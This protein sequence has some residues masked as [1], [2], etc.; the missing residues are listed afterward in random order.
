MQSVLET[1]PKWL[2]ETEVL[3]L[4]KEPIRLYDG[5]NF[6][7]RCSAEGH[8][9]PEIT[10]FKDGHVLSAATGDLTLIVF[11]VSTNIYHS[12]EFNC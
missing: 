1:A 11:S 8:P 6:I 7:L 12:P 9:I 10:W 2:N 4:T 5:E 3:R